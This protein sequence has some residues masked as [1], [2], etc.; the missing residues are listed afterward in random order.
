[1]KVGTTDHRNGATILREL[2]TVTVS[3]VPELNFPGLK[4]LWS[5]RREVTLNGATVPVSDEVRYF[6]SSIPPTLLTPTQQLDLVRLHWGI[7]NGQNWTMDVA[8][9]EDDVQPCQLT[10]A[11]SASSATICSRHGALKH[12]PRTANRSTGPDVWSCCET[13]SS[14]AATEQSPPQ[15]LDGSPAVPRFPSQTN[16]ECVP[17]SAQ[18][19]C[20]LRG[21]ASGGARSASWISRSRIKREGG[22]SRLRFGIQTQRSFCARP[23]R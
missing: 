12:P 5:L 13:H 1:M 20:A 17:P 11:G 16:Q 14:S 19:S 3:D 8:L 15:L 23:C 10:W 18:A 21:W 9:S 6:V 7:E 4:Q 2:R 22:F